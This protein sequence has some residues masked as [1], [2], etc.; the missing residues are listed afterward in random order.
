M[1]W[2]CFE[3]ATCYIWR[4]KTH[5][6]S[7]LSGQ[8]LWT[9]RCAPKPGITQRKDHEKLRKV[10]QFMMSDAL[11]RPIDRPLIEFADSFSGVLLVY[12]PIIKWLV[13]FLTLLICHFSVSLYGPNIITDHREVVEEINIPR[14][15]KLIRFIWRWQSLFLLQWQ[16][17]YCGLKRASLL[18]IPQ[19]HPSKQGL[20]LAWQRNGSCFFAWYSIFLSE[21]NRNTFHK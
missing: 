1:T 13:T 9:A 14:L 16:D 12:F 7:P 6:G 15:E 17:E 8:Q 5:G 20:R 2:Y 11:I 21:K 4:K 10:I 3:Y 18:S 19:S